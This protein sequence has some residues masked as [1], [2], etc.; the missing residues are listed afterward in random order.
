MTRE[1]G[2]PLPEL[3]ALRNAALD[4]L[5]DLPEC[6][7][8]DCSSSPKA[9]HVLTVGFSPA[10]QA[11]AKDSPVRWRCPAHAEG[12][13]PLPWAA[14]E[15]RLHMAAWPHSPQAK[16][17]P[18]PEVMA[19]EAALTCHALCD[20]AGRP[21]EPCWGSVTAV[22]IG[23]D[24]GLGHLC[25]GHVWPGDYTAASK[26]TAIVRSPSDRE[27][28]D[29]LAVLGLSDLDGWKQLAAVAARHG[30]NGVDN[31]KILAT[32][33]DQELSELGRLR[34]PVWTESVRRA[35]A[36]AIISAQWSG[37]TP[38]QAAEKIVGVIDAA[39]GR[40]GASP[41]EK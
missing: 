10:E 38:E 40:E 26:E 29:A 9:T 37:K 21:R 4:L 39:F 33:L 1:S 36:L 11:C 17:D 24:G 13:T 6:D 15:E 27:L 20:Y 25:D 41:E 34:A 23:G 19:E 18:V 35:V 14:A 12:C 30:W 16:D 22:P 5:V 3:E 8:P 2:E 31:S 32:F 28:E 7:H